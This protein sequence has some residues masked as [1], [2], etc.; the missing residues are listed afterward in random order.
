MAGEARLK[1]ANDA[2][3]SGVVLKV[4][5]L[6][7]DAQIAEATHTLGSLQDQLADQTNSFND[8]VGLP[9]ETSTDLIEP[10]ESSDQEPAADPSPAELEAAALAHNPELLSSHQA[11]KEAH[12]GLKAAW[13]E[14]IP[15]VSFVV[16]H[17]YQNGAPLLPENTYAL[18]F[19]SEWTISEFGKRI[20]LVRERRAEVAEAQESLKSTR[21]KVRI[22]VE[23]EIRKINRAETGL[24]AARRSVTARTEIVRI[25]TDQVTAKTNYESTLK[26]AEARLAD[27]KAQLFDAEMERVVAQA[28]LVRTEGLRQ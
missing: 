3:H 4:N 8:L 28:E 23:S 19:H 21:N 1:E 14:Y 16:Q 7:S 20:G 25:T 27:A 9:I 10:A 12:A 22:D 11:V 2:A 26:D 15:D 6:E 17:T 5:V 13:A 18:G 24:Q